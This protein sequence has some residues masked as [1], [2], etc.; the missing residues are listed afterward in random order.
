MQLQPSGPKL[1][2]KA[3]TQSECSSQPRHKLTWMY[4]MARCCARSDQGLVWGGSQETE[5]RGQ[6]CNWANKVCSHTRRAWLQKGKVKVPRAVQQAAS[7]GVCSTP[8]P[9]EIP[10]GM[11][12]LGG[13][14]QGITA[15]W[16]HP[17]R[18]STE[19]GG[20]PGSALGPRNW[21]SAVC[22]PP[23]PYFC[24]SPGLLFPFYTFGVMKNVPKLNCG[25]GDGN[26]T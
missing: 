15:D 14:L 21:E 23:P 16:Y 4:K 13:G 17:G 22:L 12:G 20:G 25:D 1:C 19:G 7:W 10:R 5:K 8:L 3:N 9:G 24:I 2:R 26:T 6:R 18:R 11:W